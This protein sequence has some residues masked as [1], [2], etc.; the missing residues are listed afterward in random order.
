MFWSLDR[1]YI[2]CI[3]LTL[4][5]GFAL[6]FFLVEIFMADP[7]LNV[8]ILYCLK[9]IIVFAF[10]AFYILFIQV[11]DSCDSFGMVEN[12]TTGSF[13]YFF[14]LA[15]YCHLPMDPYCCG[16]ILLPLSSG[17]WNLLFVLGDVN[18]CVCFRRRQSKIYAVC[19][20]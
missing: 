17:Q 18:F 1:V 13:L 10:W 8:R 4:Y 9:E 5:F 20:P 7:F 12:I 11:T 14:H 19:A 2:L 3:Y 16:S 6:L 15:Y